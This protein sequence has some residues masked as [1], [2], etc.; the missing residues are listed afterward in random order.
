MSEVRGELSAYLEGENYMQREAVC[1][2]VQDRSM[3]LCD[4]SE[5][6]KRHS[7][8]MWLEEWLASTLFLGHGERP[9]FLS[10]VRRE[11]LEMFEHSCGII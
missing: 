10:S 2:Q 7:Q 11:S 9:L 4:L 5:V 8:K 6:S 3:A 1:E